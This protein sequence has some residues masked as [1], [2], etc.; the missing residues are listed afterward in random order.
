M[1]TP[2]NSVQHPFELRQDP[3]YK[4]SK[5]PLDLLTEAE[6]TLASD[7]LKA[8]KNLGKYHRFPLLQLNEP[9]KDAVTRFEQA[10]IACPREAFAV[11]LNKTSGESFEGIVN[12]DEKTI[13][14]WKKLDPEK[15]GH[16]PS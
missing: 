15:D 9:S 1:N 10:G 7:I 6:L 3:A 8:E 11:I 5:H 14:E 2:I 13:T 12:L 16:P 4:S